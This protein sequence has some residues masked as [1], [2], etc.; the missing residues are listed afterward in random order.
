MQYQLQCISIMNKL[1]KVSVIS[2][3]PKVSKLSKLSK[4]FAVPKKLKLHDVPHSDR[5]YDVCTKFVS[6]NGLELQFVPE[7][8]KTHSMCIIAVSQNGRALQFVPDHIKT[9]KMC[10]VAVSETRSAMVYANEYEKLVELVIM[11]SIDSKFIMQIMHPDTQHGSYVRSFWNDRLVVSRSNCDTN[12]H[13]C[14]IYPKKEYTLTPSDII[15]FFVALIEY[16]GSKY[17][18]CAA[19]EYQDR[20]L[21]I[22]ANFYLQP[23][24]PDKYSS[25]ESCEMMVKKKGSNLR[26]ILVEYRTENICW[27]AIKNCA[28]AIEYVPDKTYEMCEYVVKKCGK[29]LRFVPMK[30]RTNC[31]CFCAT[32]Q[33]HNAFKYVPNNV[34]TTIKVM[35]YIEAIRFDITGSYISGE[36]GSGTYICIRSSL[37]PYAYSY[38]TTHYTKNTIEIDHLRTIVDWIL[39]HNPSTFTTLIKLDCLSFP[40]EQFASAY[41]NLLIKRPNAIIEIKNED[42]TDE[43]NLIAVNH[44]GLLLTHCYQ[45]SLKV[46]TA[47]VRQNIKAL[48]LVPLQHKNDVLRAIEV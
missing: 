2:T 22:L 14:F 27:S 16:R 12:I 39:A 32:K 8:H 5:T 35:H 11:G 10:C 24:C 21:E 9:L 41:K 23:K 26:K 30:Y 13:I 38:P 31:L 20:I 17:I 19:G 1:T 48:P 40:K 37:D 46:C 3:I 29:L 34:I 15:D 36:Y 25:L 47:A 43:L 4:I 7:I 28:D 33:N 18:R 42:K 44:D 6:Q 45:P